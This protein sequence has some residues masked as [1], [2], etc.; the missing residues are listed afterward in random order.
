MLD[1]QNQFAS[2]KK[3]RKRRS[4][5]VCLLVAVFFSGLPFPSLAQGSGAPSEAEAAKLRMLNQVKGVLQQNERD[6]YNQAT[7]T[8]SARNSAKYTDI[9]SCSAQAEIAKLLSLSV[10]DPDGGRF[11][12][13][14]PVTRREFVRWLVKAVNVAM[15][16]FDLPARK[17]KL[18]ESG[19]ALFWDVPAGDPDFKYIQGLANAGIAIESDNKH[20]KPEQPLTREELL[21]IKVPLSVLLDGGNPSLSGDAGKSFSAKWDSSAPYSDKNSVSPRLRAALGMIVE[22]P[23]VEDPVKLIFEPGNLLKPQQPVT[24]AEAAKCISRLGARGDF[25]VLLKD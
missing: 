15:P 19:I 12:P 8:P 16:K 7:A 25:N 22:N 17:I 13:N 10:L 4:A 24:R 23:S 3:E 1:S 20:F 9:S 21:A 18:A 6:R 11:E 5:Y 14:K 2:N